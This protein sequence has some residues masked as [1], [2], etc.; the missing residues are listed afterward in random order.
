MSIRKSL[1]AVLFVGFLALFAF[2]GCTVPASTTTHSQLPPAP[3]S[4][5]H[6]EDGIEF[7]V[8]VSNTRL[9]PGESIDITIEV[10]N[11]SNTNGVTIQ[12]ADGETTL[13]MT[14]SDGQIVWGTTVGRS[15]TTLAATITI[16]PIEGRTANI[17]WTAAKD[18]QF[19][20]PVTAGTYTLKVSDTGFFDPALNA[21]IPFS[22]SPI[23]ITV[24]S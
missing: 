18:P 22:V 5:I 11:V 17:T 12:G 13:Q 4:G 10:R 15:G 7:D 24:L 9:Y 21:Q 16:G 3:A 6:G 14:N 19:R 2:A 1:Y 23:Q 8:T 20:V